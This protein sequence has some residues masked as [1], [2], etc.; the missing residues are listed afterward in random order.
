MAPAGFGVTGE[1][2]IRCPTLA[3]LPPPPA[4]KS[5]WPWTEES[6]RLPEAVGSAAPPRITVVTPSYNQGQFL[7][8]TIRSVLLQGYADLEYMIIDGGSKDGSVEIIRK[9]APWLAYW[10]SE[11]DGG[12]TNAINNGFRRASGDLVTWINSDDL[13]HADALH[14]AG[15]ALRRYPDAGMIYG[16]GAKVD[17]AGNLI[18][19][20]PYRAYDR[21]LLQTK[22][23]ILQQSS[24][25]R[26]D[27]L[28]QIGF[29]DEALDYVMDWEMAIRISRS[30][31]ICAIPEDIGIF[32]LHA[33][34]KTQQDFWLWG[35][36]IAEVGRRYNGV[37]D[38]N[39]VTFWLR[40][41][42]RRIRQRTG[43]ERLSV[44]ESLITRALAR[45]YG[46]DR[47]MLV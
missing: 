17:V 21:R 37:T 5:G 39:F 6:L 11:R 13:L 29:L 9:Y 43:W 47:Y 16:A 34:A 40:L 18:T 24:F 26:R 23:F 30:F 36:E 2:S 35:R 22:Y 46:A 1:A 8:E 12:Q 15:R 33:S 27:V 3:E 38:P 19:K 25:I 7:E 44:L 28:A 14:A 20:I 4:G 10:V 41:A 45:L 31:S 32:R 42:C